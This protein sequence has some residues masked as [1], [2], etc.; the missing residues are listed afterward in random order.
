MA[1]GVRMWGMGERRCGMGSKEVW[2]WK[3]GDGAWGVRRSDIGSKDMW[4]GE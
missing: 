3:E 1:W 4:H 2:Y